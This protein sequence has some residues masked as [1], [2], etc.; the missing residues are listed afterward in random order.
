MDQK[1]YIISMCT[2]IIFTCF[3][4]IKGRD[5]WGSNYSPNVHWTFCIDTS[6]SMKK[7]GHMDLLRLIT[8]KITNEFLDASKNV[9]RTGDR[10]SIFSFDEG[11]RLEATALYQTESD[12]LAIRDKLIQMNE[13]NGSLTFISEAIVQSIDFTEKYSKFFHTNALYIFTDGKSEPYSNKWPNEKRELRKK[14]DMENFKKISLLGR[15]DELNVW[16]GVLRWEAFNDAKSLVTKMGKG[17]HLVDLTDFN[18]LSLEKALANFAETVRS[19]V[20]LPD[21][22]AIDFGTIPYKHTQPYE[23]HISFNIQAQKMDQ[24]PSITGRISFDPDN[25]SEITP[26]YPLEIKTTENKMV[27]NF[28]LAESSE[29]EPGTY[30]GKLNVL[31]SQMQFG[32]VVIEPSQFEVTFKKSGYLSFYI[33]RVL[34]G[35]V[36]SFLFFFYFTNKV[37]SRMPIKV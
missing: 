34:T 12:I 1:K 13:R 10:I 25:P 35:L 16:V 29:L 7:K 33:W 37:R 32:T 5:C 26:D 36:I 19:T 9:I 28:E 15:D 27:L 3:F 22:K 30:R 20:R 6:G 18:R 8:D 24:P 2:F 23:K 11:V 14:R 21:T 4:S 17:G 31:P